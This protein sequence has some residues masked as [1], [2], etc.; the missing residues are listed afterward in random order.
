MGRHK[1]LVLLSLSLL[2]SATSR[3]FYIEQ[4]HHEMGSRQ[5]TEGLEIVQKRAGDYLELNQQGPEQ[6]LA[7]EPP[8]PPMPACGHNHDHR[9]HHV[10]GLDLAKT[11]HD[12]KNQ[13]QNKSGSEA[14]EPHQHNKDQDHEPGV[15]HEHHEQHEH[16]GHATQDPGMSPGLALLLRQLGFAELAANILWIQMDADSHRGLW[17]RVEVALELIPALDPTFID[18]YLLRSFL[19][20][21]YLGRHDEALQILENAVKQVPYRI[22]LW[23]QIGIFCLNHSGRHGPTRRLPRALEAFQ[24]MVRFDDPLPQSPRLIAVTLAAME[25]RDEAVSILQSSASKD[26]REP[27]QKVLDLKMIDRIRSGE[28]F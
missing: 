15:K 10:T 13:A 11:D 3:H 14:H 6:A 5:L 21:T 2:I 17:H 12:F 9:H 25:R 16:H 1:Y 18:A 7:D 19:L 4:Y 26:N 20:D 27:D 24:Q 23:Q 22:E 8:T 28:K